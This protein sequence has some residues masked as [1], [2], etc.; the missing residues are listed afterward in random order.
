MGLTF[1]AMFS[2]AESSLKPE[3]SVLGQ[4]EI[5]YHVCTVVIKNWLEIHVV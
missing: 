2:T 4:T 5:L 1:S 3:F